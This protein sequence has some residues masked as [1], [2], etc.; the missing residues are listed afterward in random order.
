M[1]QY[2]IKD[3]KDRKTNQTRT[4]GVQKRWIGRIVMKPY[5]SVMG[6]EIVPSLK[7]ANGKE[8]YEILYTSPIQDVIFKE[9]GDITVV[10]L[11]SIY[12]F[13]YLGDFE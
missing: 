7:D 6:T 2:R 1:I 5:P 4:D 10:T 8:N 13:E 12:E 9:N 11:N 3:I